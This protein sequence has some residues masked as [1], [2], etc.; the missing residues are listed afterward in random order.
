M[1]KY[2]KHRFRLCS[3]ITITIILI[4]IYSRNYF[5]RNRCADVIRYSKIIA[6]FVKSIFKKFNK[7]FETITLSLD[8]WIYVF[9]LKIH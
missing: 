2:L 4:K 3:F 9:V 1:G 7:K 8:R 5:C 6:S